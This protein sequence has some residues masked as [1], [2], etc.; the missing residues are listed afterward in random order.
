M[1]WKRNGRT[2][3]GA[4]HDGGMPRRE[5]RS[6]PE[7]Q[8]RVRARRPSPTNLRQMTTPCVTTCRMSGSNAR[9]DRTR[10]FL[11]SREAA[12]RCCRESI[13][14]AARKQ[15]ADNTSGPMR[16][17]ER[18]ASLRRIP[19]WP[20]RSP[21][22]PRPNTRL[23]LHR[24]PDADSHGHLRRESI[25]ELLAPAAVNILEQQHLCKPL[26]TPTSKTALRCKSIRI[27]KRAK[28]PVPPSDVAVVEV[29]HTILMV[30]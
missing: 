24:L 13:R 26:L 17:I 3:M 5:L 29:V 8:R 20:G 1:S 11:S 25:H 23:Q 16:P 6:R 30:N 14:E 15:Q 12:A 7:P 2:A 4:L 9:R 22:N 21:P 10:A 19:S 27:T 28:Q 18:V